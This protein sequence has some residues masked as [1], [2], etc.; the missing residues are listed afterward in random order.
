MERKV[1]VP[2]VET[3]TPHSY[4][5]IFKFRRCCYL[6]WSAD[7]KIMNQTVPSLHSAHDREARQSGVQVVVSR[8][9]ED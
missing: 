1:K 5:I 8:I 2:M 4:N 7:D 9:D 6:A 3:L